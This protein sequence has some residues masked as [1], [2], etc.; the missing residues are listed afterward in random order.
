MRIAVHYKPDAV[1]SRE[2]DRPHLQHPYLDVAA[3][4]IV[5]TDGKR[6]VTVPVDCD[7]GEVSGH[8]A[9]DL[10][11][12][13]R[14]TNRKELVAQIRERREVVPQAIEWPCNVVGEF[15]AWREIIPGFRPGDAG[16]ITIGV[17]ARLLA[18]IAAA[19]GTEG[20]VALTFRLDSIDA[21][22][23]GRGLEPQILVRSVFAPQEGELGVLMP[24]LLDRTHVAVPVPEAGDDSGGPAAVRAALEKQADATLAAAGS[25]DLNRAELKGDAVA[26]KPRKGGR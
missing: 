7:E 4:R 10:L 11:K 24:I 14:K 25:G 23:P 12:V 6:L 15:P 21:E 13:A 22:A 9:S 19:L 3:E 20:Q 26:Q 16:T 5:A 17:N 8:I 1:V 18:G 2:K